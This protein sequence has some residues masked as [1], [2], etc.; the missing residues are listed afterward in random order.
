MILTIVASLTI[1]LIHF[2]V[3]QKPLAGNLLQKTRQMDWLG[4]VLSLSMSV[5]ILVSI[6]GISRLTARC[7]S[8]EAAPLLLGQARL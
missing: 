8:A 5:C 2:T 3:P 7:Q 4:T 6:A 1:V